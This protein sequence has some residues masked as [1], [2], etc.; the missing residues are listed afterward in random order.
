[1]CLH[2]GIGDYDY[3]GGSGTGPNPVEGPLRVLP[4][5]PFDLDGN[6]DDGI[7]RESGSADTPSL[8]SRSCTCGSRLARHLA[9][10]VRVAYDQSSRSTRE[11]P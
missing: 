4:P 1:V 3:A 9:S 2:Q 8:T 11:G 6:D 10:G 5:A 7:G